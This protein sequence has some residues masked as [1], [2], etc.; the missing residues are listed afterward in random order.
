VERL[1]ISFRAFSWLRRL[2]LSFPGKDQCFVD[3][4]RSPVH[5]D[6]SLSP[7]PSPNASSL[8]PRVILNSEASRGAHFAAKF[9][10]EKRSCLSPAK[11]ET[12]K[13]AGFAAVV[14]KA[15]SGK[16]RMGRRTQAHRNGRPSTATRRQTKFCRS[17]ALPIADHRIRAGRN[18][19]AIPCGRTIA[20]R[21]SRS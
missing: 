13:V 16:V 18:R 6:S 1:T 5:P 21:L 12:R 14:P 2:F 19:T 15:D 4:T 10:I 9:R 17:V 20:I 11:V 8:L 7:S 3:Y